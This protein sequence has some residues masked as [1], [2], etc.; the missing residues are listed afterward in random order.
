MPKIKFFIVLINLPRLLMHILFF[1]VYYNK[2]RDDVLACMK[3][4][5]FTISVFWSFCYLLVFDKTY[6]NLF[7]RRVG[8]AKYLMWYWLLPHPCFTLASNMKIGPGF[9]CVHPFATIVNAKNVGSNF[10]VRNN[11][12]IGNNKRGER[13]QIGNNVSINANAVVIGD[14]TL[15]NNVVVGA[16]TVLTKSVPD[17]CIVVG[18]PAYILK[19]NG[20]T[21]KKE[22]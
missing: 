8:N 6:R 18:N 12:T 2:C 20:V 10:S 13:P 17:N 11:V 4:R 5:P 9:Q 22:L 19:E 21:V 1:Y 15:G 16:G 14:I 3:L 7:Y